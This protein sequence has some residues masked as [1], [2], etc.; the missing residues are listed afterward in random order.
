MKLK[1]KIIQSENQYTSLFSDIHKTSNY[2]IHYNIENKSSHDSNNALVLNLNTDINTI[3]LEIEDFYI[4]KDIWPRFYQ[5][6]LP[7]EKEILFPVLKKLNYTIEEEKLE[8]YVQTE[9][10]EIAINNNLKIYRITSINKEISDLMIKGDGGD[11]NLRRIE[12]FLPNNK[13][14]CLGL[15]NENNTLVALASLCIGED[16]SRIDDV[17]AHPD[18]RGKEYGKQLTA[19][20]L[21]YHKQHSDN[22]LFLFADNPVAIN[23][24]QQA[25]FR[26]SEDNLS[27]WSAFK[28]IRDN[29][30]V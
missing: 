2:S 19:H 18:F 5:A 1:D 29:N 27:C 16:I 15:K 21:K 13:L 11:W 22:D 30:Q 26:K 25:G 4:S 12:R 24:Y 17:L 20:M 7:N 6:Y 10:S 9:K 3:I 8:Y 23:I 14:H 28:D